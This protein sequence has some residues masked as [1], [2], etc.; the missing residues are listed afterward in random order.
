M[1][2]ELSRPFMLAANISALKGTA[3]P[4]FLRNLDSRE[5]QIL[6]EEASAYKTELHNYSDKHGTWKKVHGVLFAGGMLTSLAGI[7]L[8]GSSLATTDLDSPVNRLINKMVIGGMAAGF[9]GGIIWRTAKDA[10]NNY[11]STLEDG[12]EQ[13]RSLRLQEKVRLIGQELLKEDLEPGEIH[14]LES[15]KEYFSQKTTLIES[16]QINRLRIIVPR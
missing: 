14:Q 10:E 7:S 6:A 13:N 16:S 15:A 4:A 12:I 3:L 5:L 11:I 9:Y 8:I 1:S 2:I